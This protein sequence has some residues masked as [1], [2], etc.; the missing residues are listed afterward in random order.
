MFSCVWLHFKKCFEKYFLMFGCALENIIENTF[1]TCCSHFLTFSWLPNE[2]IIS[3]IP[4]NTKKKPRKRSSN[5]DTSRNRDRR[6]SEIAIGAK[7]RSRSVLRANAI[8]TVGTSRDRDRHIAQSRSRSKLH[9]IG[10]VPMM[11]VDSAVPVM[12]RSLLSFSLSLFLLLSL[13]LLFSLVAFHLKWKWKWK[14]FSVVLALI[15]GQLKMLFSLTKFEVTTKHPIILQSTPSHNF[16]IF[17]LPQL[18]TIYHQNNTTPLPLFSLFLYLTHTHPR[19]PSC[20][21][22]SYSSLCHIGMPF[23]TTPNPPTPISSLSIFASL[24]IT[25]S[26]A[27]FCFLGVWIFGFHFCECCAFFW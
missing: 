14:W 4:Q 18:P 22:R 21:V 9:A 2:Y 25:L 16:T 15:F 20:H 11:W 13:S 26:F 7:A 27:G 24:Y 17:Q 23:P 1:F 3:F 5:P 19:I 12:S 8:G 10:A 6:E